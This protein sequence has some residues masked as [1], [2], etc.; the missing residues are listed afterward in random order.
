[1]SPAEFQ[2]SRGKNVVCF[3]VVL[4]LLNLFLWTQSVLINNNNNHN[5]NNN[6]NN[7]K[8]V[9]RNDTDPPFA[10]DIG[11]SRK[12]H[13]PLF[14]P[15]RGPLTPKRGEDTSG[16]IVRLHAKFGVSRPAGCREIVDKKTSKKHT[17][18][19]IPVRFDLTSEWPGN[20]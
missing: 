16:T 15:S 11:I 6:N 8:C 7:N 19:L 18:K 20:K 2:K 5:N 3:K 12:F 4:Q 13:F 1:M 14:P 9:S 10:F 17:V